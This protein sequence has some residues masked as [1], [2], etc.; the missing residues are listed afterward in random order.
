MKIFI[1][2]V[3]SFLILASVSTSSFAQSGEMDRFNHQS[4]EA[5]TNVV[6]MYPNPTVDY[7]N[8]R[9]ENSTLAET[10]F[11]VH[12]II[13][14]VMEATVEPVGENE[15]RIKVKDLAP[16]YYLLAIRDDQGYFKETYKF[17][18]R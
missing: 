18:K 9:I 17:L 15:F 4:L 8:V 7:I 12:N 6:R 16:G 3:L 13:G 11:T 2:T 1:L 5:R 14:N 10:N